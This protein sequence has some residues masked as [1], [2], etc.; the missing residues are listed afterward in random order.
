MN[1]L[2]FVNIVSFALILTVSLATVCV[3]WF[4]HKNPSKLRH[5]APGDQQDKKAEAKEI[6]ADHRLN[7]LADRNIAMDEKLREYEERIAVLERALERADR[8]NAAE[9]AALRA[10]NRELRKKLENLP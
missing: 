8:D 7:R 10:E 5:R 4:V 3:A 6:Q 9:E 1:I 2:Q